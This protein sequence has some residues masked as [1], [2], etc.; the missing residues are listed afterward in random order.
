MYIYLYYIILIF[1]CVICILEYLVICEKMNDKVIEF[2]FKYYSEE[3]VED[4][5]IIIEN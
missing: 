2:L 1:V 5:L 4:V 3:F